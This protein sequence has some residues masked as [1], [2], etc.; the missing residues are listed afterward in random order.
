[1]NTEDASLQPRSALRWFTSSYSSGAGGECVEVA[2]E[3]AAVHVRDSKRVTQGG[4]V[5]K[6][7]SEAW[8]AL[9]DTM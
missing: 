8:S 2:V 5:L 7:S 4:P 1:M 6:V 3:A 9:L